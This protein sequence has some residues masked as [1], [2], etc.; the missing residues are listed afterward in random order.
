M[1]IIIICVSFISMILGV[2]YPILL[3][4][5]SKLDE[6]YSSTHI[7]QLFKQEKERKIFNTL[8]ISSLGILLI[9]ILIVLPYYL[10]TDTPNQHLIFIIISIL[11]INTFS[12]TAVFL[13]FV[14]K[15]L[16]YYNL[17]DIVQYF[18]HKDRK[19]L[20]DINF[21]YF[22]AI[23][24]IL[25]F[26]I[27][28]RN[29][30]IA[31][32]I[33]DYVYE[34]F[35]EFNKYHT[36]AEIEYP[37]IFHESIFRVIE[38]LA[39]EKIKKFAFLEFS[40]IGELW[41]LGENSN[42]KLNEATYMWLWRNLIVAIDYERD[43]MFIQYWQQADQYISFNLSTYQTDRL[44]PPGEERKT[45]DQ[46]I[47]ERNRF[48][49]FNY[50][51]G[52][53]LLFSKRYKC[54]RR[55]FQY[56]SS[57][58]P[59]YNL[60]PDSMDEV[61]DLYFKFSDP[62][63][64]NFRFIT[65]RY[66][67]PETEGIGSEGV[68]KYWV[69]RYAT[70]LFLRQY[71]IA[72]YLITMKPLEMPALPPDLKNKKMWIDHLDNLKEMVNNVMED[73]ELILSLDL[74]FITGKWC[75]ENDKLPPDKLVDEVK[76]KALK[77][78][79]HIKTDQNI[80]P[81]KEK[82]FIETSDRVLS[83]AITPYKQIKNLKNIT[84][85]ANKWHIPGV[86]TIID[87]SIFA[88]NQEAESIDYDSFLP[89]ILANKFTDGISETFAINLKRKYI[90]NENEIFP[91]ILNLKVNPNDHII[92]SFG[93]NPAYYEETL[94]VEGLSADAFNEVN[95]INFN[96]YNY[97]LVGETF[98][99]LKKSDLLTLEFLPP[100]EKDEEKYSLA[101]INKDFNIYGSIIDLNKNQ[102]LCEELSKAETTR[103][104]KKSVFVYLFINTKILWKK[105]IT[106]IAITK[107]SQF[108][109]QG[110]KNDLEEIIP[111]KETDKDS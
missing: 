11:I 3:Q 35:R 74:D 95:W 72:P 85:E 33:S 88:E 2:A 49:E 30:T 42:K 71:T 12:L 10:L 15:V 64:E 19:A 67:F 22:K 52:G 44:L 43:D 87:K 48:L 62:Y 78:F 57:M 39:K 92:V 96:S 97:N 23:I 29:E 107:Y 26:S 93:Q 101:L 83:T 82:E 14:T 27:K 47:E 104:L 108:R 51:L 1:T 56:T 31:L 111:F 45:K 75:S 54:I 50:A 17:F 86:T 9:Y 65:S 84:G 66:F 98:F 6:K 76:S 105:N 61:F 69:S 34:R 41:L 94:K 106:M 46:I 13:Y 102:S 25:L 38:E 20:D 99:V 36:N 37:R 70:L 59:K 81:S 32:T 89:E 4:V 103:D 77:E 58:P 73:Q 100:D 68:V 110:S 21:P 53:L 60:L 7:V 91:A 8:L 5:I 80:S 79:D 55:L 40:F 16:T 63:Y 24:D 90:V 109:P 18:K 28:Q